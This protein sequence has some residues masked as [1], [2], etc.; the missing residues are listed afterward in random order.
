MLNDNTSFFH[1]W[2]VMIIF[3]SGRGSCCEISMPGMS[4]PPTEN[5][6][7]ILDIEGSIYSFGDSLRGGPR[8][9]AETAIIKFGIHSFEKK[10]DLLEENSEEW[11][12]S[13]VKRPLV[14][15]STSASFLF[16]R[17]YEPQI[18]IEN[19]LFLQVF[20]LNVRQFYLYLLKQSFKKEILKEHIW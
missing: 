18:M 5:W 15:V 10:W 6:N 13:A 20:S 2:E 11:N 1:I 9:P 7:W 3:H 17:L 19:I 16:W 4:T 14:R 8:R 12:N